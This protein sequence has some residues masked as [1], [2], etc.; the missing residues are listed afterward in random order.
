MWKNRPHAVVL[1]SSEP[2]L[3]R[4]R[5]RT[6]SSRKMR[7]EQKKEEWRGRGGDKKTLARKPHDFEEL[8]SHAN[9][10]S[11]WCGVTLFYFSFRSFR[12]HLRAK[13]VCETRAWSARK[14]IFSSSPTPTP[15]RWRSIN[16]L[17]F[18]FH[19]P[20]STDFEEKILEGSFTVLRY[21]LYALSCLIQFN[22]MFNTNNSINV[23]RLI[24]VNILRL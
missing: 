17:R 2:S 5:F 8:R 20:R 4:K 23:N 18:I 16:P 9:A 13:R 19:H 24:K 21:H 22:T 1:C 11:D 12:K 6:S 14:K 3:C 10:A 7:R 15:L